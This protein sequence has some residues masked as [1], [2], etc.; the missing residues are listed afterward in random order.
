MRGGSP[1]RPDE[2]TGYANPG[3][4]RSLSEFGEPIRTAKSGASLLIRE[5]PG[6]TLRDAVTPYPIFVCERWADLAGDLDSLPSD[7]VSVAVVTDPFGDWT[8]ELLLRTFRDHV[9]RYKDHNVVDVTNPSV[10]S[11]HRRNVRRALG[12]V[13]VAEVEDPI[14]MVDE[15]TE[16]YEHLVRRH[17]ISG[18]AEFSRAA[19][20]AQLALPGMV[21]LRGT[22]AGEL[23]GIVLCFQSGD[24]A[25]YHLGAY[26]PLGYELRASYALFDG[27]IT[28]LAVRGCRQLSLGAGAGVAN[29]TT[30]GLTRFKR[31]WSTMTLPTYFCGRVID[32]EAYQSLSRDVPE[33]RYFPCYRSPVLP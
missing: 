9:V 3:Y 33:S 4:A 12:Q 15:W 7:L 16:L 25:Y 29:D 19:F 2:L 8:S 21:A 6:T 22:H 17:G 24:H 26:T 30:D 18:V 23:V 20:R 32:R 5:I 1:R 27:L 31:G 28:L 14:G 10:D 13:D 11:H